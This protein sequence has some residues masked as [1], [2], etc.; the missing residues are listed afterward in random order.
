[1]PD[2]ILLI[3]RCFQLFFQLFF[4]KQK[5]LL[6]FKINLIKIYVFFKSIIPYASHYIAGIVLFSIDIILL[7]NFGTEN[8]LGIYSFLIRVTAV[9]FMIS[10]VILN[11]MIPYL[12]KLTLVNKI[13]FKKNSSLIYIINIMNICFKIIKI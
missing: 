9:I 11:V 6:K 5:E 12:S 2:F 1:M 8:E 7:E 4:V 3:G 13:I 10:E